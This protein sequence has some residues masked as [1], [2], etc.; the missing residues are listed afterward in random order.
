MKA[1]A[2][3]NLAL[4]I[5]NRRQDGF[6]DLRMVM[7]SVT[8]FDTV[9]VREAGTGFT[10]RAAGFAPAGEKSLEQRAAEAFFAALGRPAPGLEVTVEK[11]IP[12]YAG[13]G[14][15]SAD[16]AAVL[17]IL[18]ERYAPEL[19]MADLEAIGLTVGSDVPF[20]L[21]RG[22][23]LAEGR[24][25]RMR[26]LPPLPECWILLWKPDFD[27]PTGRMFALADG[28][29]ITRRPDFGAMERALEAGDLEGTARQLC[30]VFEEALP[31]HCRRAVDVGRE[32]LLDRG[33]LGAAMSG[34]GPT[35]FGLFRDRETA[36][37]A[38]EIFPAHQVFLARPE[39]G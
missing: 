12:A 38:M 4:D 26:P 36:E 10:L 1:P 16:V 18:R 31:D 9:E 27:L 22:T 24:G 39:R 19:P 13:L 5:L 8:L 15:G 2:K 11:R 37:G 14:G 7:Q 6:H 35:V 28:A 30:N 32:A 25:E 3:I 20:C 23:C 33:A 21:R 17:R 29:V 34:S